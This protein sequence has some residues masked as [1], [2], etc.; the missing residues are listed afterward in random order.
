MSIAKLRSSI[1]RDI[2]WL[3]NSVHLAAT[4]DLSE[5]PLVAQSVL[6][7]GVPSFAGESLDRLGIASTETAIRQAILQFEP[8][9]LPNSVKVRLIQESLRG[10]THNR[11]ALEIDAEFWCQPL[12]LQMFLKTELDLEIGAARVI[13][14]SESDR[15]EKRGRGRR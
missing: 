1:L 5:C 3:L 12:P 13:E 9:L 2:T 10:D 4:E 11:I 6:N 7:Y 14:Q 8:R 15:V